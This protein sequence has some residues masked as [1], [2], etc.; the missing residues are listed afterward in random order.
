MIG[1]GKADWGRWLAVLG[2]AVMC[3]GA[4]AQAWPSKPVKMIVTFTPGSAV[5]L[6]ARTLSDHLPAQLGQP[7]MVEMPKL[8]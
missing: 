8:R 3:G 7:V 5:D 4:F 1:A 6:V 2:L